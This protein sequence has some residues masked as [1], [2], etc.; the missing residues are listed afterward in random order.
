MKGKNDFVLL[1]KSQNGLKNGIG[2]KETGRECE[3]RNM[4]SNKNNECNKNN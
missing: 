4:N 2:L 1:K 3:K